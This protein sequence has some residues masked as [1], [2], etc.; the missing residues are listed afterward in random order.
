MHFFLSKV[1][2]KSLSKVG[3]KLAHIDIEW[4]VGGDFNIDISCKKIT[5]KR[6]FYIILLI[7]TYSIKLLL[8]RQDY[9]HRPQLLYL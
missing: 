4:I 7:N 1:G 5:K 8:N 9:A 3:D 2:D 6:G